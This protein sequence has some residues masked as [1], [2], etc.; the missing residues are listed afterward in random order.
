MQ[1]SITNYILIFLLI[2]NG[3]LHAQK[4]S[5]KCDELTSCSDCTS[6]LNIKAIGKIIFKCSPIG[7]GDNLEIKNNPS[8][9]I[10]FAKEHNTVWLKFRAVEEGFLTFK[11]TPDNIDYDYD[12]SLFKVDKDANCGEIINKSVKPIRS[13]ISRNNK[14]KNSITGL[15]MTA[16]NDFIPSGI[17]EIYSKALKVTK[18]DYFI[19]SI[20]NVYKGNDGFSLKFEYL[21]LKIIEGEV[22]DEKTGEPLKATLAWENT[23]TGEVLASTTSNSEDGKFRLEAPVYVNDENNTEF[24][25]SSYINNYFFKES[26]VKTNSIDFQFISPIEIV[27]PKLEKGKKMKLHNINFHGDLATYFNSAK[28]TLRRLKKLMA[29]NTTL[30]IVIEGHTNGAVTTKED[31]DRTQKLSEDRAMAIK[32]YLISNGIDKKRIETIGYNSSRMLYPNMETEKQQHL[33]RRVE[34]LVSDY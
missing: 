25:L 29:L 10:Y 16:K 4:T 33:N 18:G 11:L 5:F 3:Y 17:G 8:N 27:L 19:L 14:A 6:A 30:A 32:N 15:S 31:L 7:H 2:F 22:K 24:T 21:E 28:P 9:S 34:I 13:N 20:D 12:Y 23:K 26:F 1:H